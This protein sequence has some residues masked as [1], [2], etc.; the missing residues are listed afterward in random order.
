MTPR[1]SLIDVTRRE[2]LGTSAAATA[3]I[4]AAV[5]PAADQP[6]PAVMGYPSSLSVLPGERVSLHTSGS[7]TPVPSGGR[8]AAARGESVT[9]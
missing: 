9:S 6:L 5:P 8:S 4:A 1:R 3:A 2:F 7:A